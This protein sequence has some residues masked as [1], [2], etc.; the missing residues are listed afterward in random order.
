MKRTLFFLLFLFYSNISSAINAIEIYG[1]EDKVSEIILKRYIKEIETVESELDKERLAE[2]ITGKENT[3]KID[4]LNAKETLLQE[5]IKKDGQFLFVYIHTTSYPTEKTSY[6]TIE[7]VQKNQP[8]RLRFVNPETPINNVPH[9]LDLI[10]KMIEYNELGDKLAAT[11]QLDPYDYSCPAYHCVY[12]FTHRKLKPYLQIFNAGA[13]NQRE[14]I[15]DTLNKD[16]NPERRATAAF[17]VGHFTDPKEILSIL[18][19]HVNDNYAVV[20]NNVMRVISATMSKAHISDINVEP[21]LDLLNSPYGTDRNKALGTLFEAT[22]SKSA[23]EIIIQKG[24]ENLLALLRL[25]QPNNHEYAYLIL[26]KISG[27]N[28]DEYDIKKWEDWFS[29]AEKYR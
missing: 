16:M 3:K 26:R 12:G 11:H 24:K 8:E 7:V 10:D 29:T 17:L 21:F 23:K 22:A 6:T 13:L 2:T 1:A 9:T 18:L 15:L 25:K 4:T 14:L 28:Y 5:K 20:R 19:P 27:K